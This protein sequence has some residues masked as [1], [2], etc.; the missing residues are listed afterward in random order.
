MSAITLEKSVSAPASAGAIIKS[1]LVHVQPETAARPRLK[2]AAALAG[3]LG[4]HLIGIGAE[5]VNWAV[6]VEPSGVPTGPLLEELLRVVS[7]N[8]TRAKA[9]FAE[10]AGEAGNEFR[11]VE[12]DPLQAMLNAARE[13]DLIVAGGSPLGAG[14]PY[15]SCDPAELALRS[16]L[17]VLVVPPDGGI[18]K[19]QSIVVAWKDTRESRRALHDAMP[20]LKAAQKVMVVSVCEAGDAKAA[21]DGVRE[22]VAGLRRHGVKAEPTVVHAAPELAAARV[23]DEAREARADLIVSGAYGHSR[24]GEWIFGGVTHYLL[25]NPQTFLLLSH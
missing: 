12:G 13:A 11:A 22:V 25:H 1:I 17:P 20:F 16:G 10:A 18:L 8:L 3:A 23:Q 9:S 14:D 7:E 15:R 24:L 6:A 19:A 2:A 4:S 21:L 5:T